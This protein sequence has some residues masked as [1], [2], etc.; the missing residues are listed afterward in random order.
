MKTPP[1]KTEKEAVESRCL[2]GWWTLAFLAPPI[3]IADEDEIRSSVP[4]IPLEK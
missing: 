3:R 1:Y 2:P 4:T